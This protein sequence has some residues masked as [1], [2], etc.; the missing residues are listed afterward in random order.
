MA[1]ES[2]KYIFE[3]DM[4]DSWD[5]NI[6][7]S[8]TRIGRFGNSLMGSN[9][10]N[11]VRGA[12]YRGPINDSRIFTFGGTTFIANTTDPDWQAPSSDQYSLWSYDTTLMTWG[13]YDISH[14][15]PRRPAWGSI[16]EFMAKGV[17]FFL[18]GEIDRGSSNVLYSTAEYIGGSLANGTNDEITY[19]GG[20]A[21]IDMPTQ[22]ARNVS[23]EGLGAP[24]V[25]GGL[26]HTP[27]FGKSEDGTLVAF[28]GMRS[29]NAGIDTFSN[30]ILVLT[31]PVRRSMVCILTNLR[32]T[33]TPYHYAIPSWK[34]M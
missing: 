33:S 17:A 12:L 7:L 25:S 20:M 16:A 28:G 29:S 2:G 18:N 26:V 30:G 15:V 3:I 9:P 4:S 13:Q 11:M 32:L 21:V 14:A 1:Y 5:A 24:R 8:E 31:Y 27:M 6:N 10:P 22:T 34:R 23:T 19:L